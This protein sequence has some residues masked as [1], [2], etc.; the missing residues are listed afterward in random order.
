MYST[1]L[2]SPAINLLLRRRKWSKILRWGVLGYVLPRLPLLWS[3]GVFRCSISLRVI[4]VFKD[5]TYLI[6]IL[7]SWHLVIY[8]HFWLYVWNNWFGVM[9]TMSTWFWHKKWVWQLTSRPS[10]SATMWEKMAASPLSTGM[11][12]VATLRM[13]TTLQ[14]PLLWGMMLIPLVLQELGADVRRLTALPNGGLATQILTSLA[15]KV[16]WD[17]QSRRLP[18]DLHHLHSRCRREWGHHGWHE[19]ASRS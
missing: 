1:L 6:I 18:V 19:S 12:G 3:Y 8:E 7:Y 11:R 17:H 9:H 15:R 5:I 16:Q 2:F 4:I 10:S 13:T 14:M